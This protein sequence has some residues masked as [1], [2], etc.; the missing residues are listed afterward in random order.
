MNTPT[1][2]RLTPISAPSPASKPVLG[3]VLEDAA[4]AE[5]VPV[6]VVVVL[7]AV[8][9]VG[10]AEDNGVVEVPLPVGVGVEVVGELVEVVCEPDPLWL[11]ASGSVYWLSPAEGPPAIAEAGRDRTIAASTTS[12]VSVTRQ[13]RT[14]RVLH[15]TRHLAA[16]SI[17]LSRL[18]RRPGGITDP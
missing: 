16:T 17:C 13:E 12:Q 8:V 11:F 5:A 6:L 18:R 7:D 14:A 2:I 3:R 9:A 1:P 4:E 10:D 15:P